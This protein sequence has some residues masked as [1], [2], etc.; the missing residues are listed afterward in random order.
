[1]R[2]RLDFDLHDLKQQ[3]QLRRIGRDLYGHGD[4]ISAQ[5]VDAMAAVLS[6]LG[7]AT[8]YRELLQEG[9]GEAMVTDAEARHL[10]NGST[11]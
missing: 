8:D 7:S 3:A 2:T 6:R 5:S 9:F 4:V 10:A 11:R 1:M